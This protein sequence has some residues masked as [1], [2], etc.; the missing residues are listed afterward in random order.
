[1]ISIPDISKWDTSNVTQF[2][3]IFVNCSSLISIPDISK[4]DIINPKDIGYLFDG[5]SS[6][7]LIPDITKWK[8]S[9]FK[10]MSS[11]FGFLHKIHN[12]NIDMEKYVN[13]FDDFSFNY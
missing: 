5:C 10:N 7:I 11:S 1:M 6:L 12:R 9:N 4:W 13:D 3:E 8:V 2:R